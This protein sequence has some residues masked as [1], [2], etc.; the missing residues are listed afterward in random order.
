MKE[1]LM[2]YET[3]ELKLNQVAAGAGIRYE[4]LRVAVLHPNRQVLTPD[5]LENL[6]AWLLKFGARITAAVA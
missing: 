5:E 2:L 6:R 1:L 3:P 4:K